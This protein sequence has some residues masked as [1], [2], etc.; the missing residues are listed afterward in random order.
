MFLFLVY[1]ISICHFKA[2]RKKQCGEFGIQSGEYKKRAQSARLILSVIPSE[3][4]YHVMLNELRRVRLV[5]ADADDQF[6]VGTVS[7][8]SQ[9]GEKPFKRFKRMVHDLQEAVN[10]EILKVKIL[11]RNAGK[12][13]IKHL[14]AIDMGLGRIHKADAVLKFEHVLVVVVDKNDAALCGIDRLISH[15]DDPLRLT[16]AL[17][18]ENHSYQGKSPPLRAKA[19]PINLM[20]LL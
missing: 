15:V 8:L 3:R 18:A 19:L 7:K 11:R 2:S 9:F 5:P 17:F 14:G 10:K 20:H 16:R 6:Y 1:V 4:L 13:A 12:E